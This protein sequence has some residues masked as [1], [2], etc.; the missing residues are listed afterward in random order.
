MLRQAGLFYGLPIALALGLCLSASA[1][2]AEASAAKPAN[3]KTM[4]AD[5]E[6]ALEQAVEVARAGD[7]K[8]GLRLLDALIKAHP[9][10]YPA[11]RDFIVVA[12]WDNQCELAWQRFQALKSQA[13]YEDYLVQ[14]LSECLRDMRRVEEAKA[15]L[16]KAAAKNPDSEDIKFARQD[17]QQAMYWRNRPELSVNVGSSESDQGAREWHVQ[18]R[19]SHPLSQATRVYARYLIKR[20]TDPQF[21]TGNMYRAGI[22]VRTWLSDDDLLDVEASTDVKRGEEQGARLDYTHLLGRRWEFGATYSSYY[23]DVSLRAKAQGISA[24]NAGLSTAFHTLDY[25]YEWSASVSRSHFSDTNTRNSASTAG[26]YAFELKPER[27]MRVLL[28]LYQADNNLT[29]VVYY[30]PEHDFTATLSLRTDWVLDTKYERHVQHFTVY[31]ADHEQ[32]HYDSLINYGAG[33]G[34][35]LQISKKS[36]VNLQANYGRASYDGNYEDEGSVEL[37]YTR[38]F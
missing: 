16:K 32:R 38:K 11:R 2:Q 34:F 1:V 22:G 4:P 26:S 5:P 15:L 9:D 13:Q 17:L 3:A 23:E 24:N 18:T 29:N 12:A 20:A 8:R 33:Y 27:E 37:T 6:Q 7:N 19:Y 25:R 36:A 35:E 14:P 30:N 10:F 21:D 28:D 31:V